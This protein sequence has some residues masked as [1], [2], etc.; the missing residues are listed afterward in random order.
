MLKK[1]NKNKNLVFKFSTVQSKPAHLTRTYGKLVT[2]DVCYLA[3]RPSGSKGLI[4]WKS[5]LPY[6]ITFPDRGC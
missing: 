6:N 5:T 3:T 1:K 2:M 4:P